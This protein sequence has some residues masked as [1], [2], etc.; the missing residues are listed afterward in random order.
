MFKGA[1]QAES[2]FVTVP[3]FAPAKQ[4]SVL[5]KIIRSIII[6]FDKHRTKERR[7]WNRLL[8]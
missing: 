6:E 8:K 1:V 5:T 4:W 3:F 7:I 2:G